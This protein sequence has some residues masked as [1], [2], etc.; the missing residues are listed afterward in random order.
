[1]PTAW[2]CLH[3]PS[4]PKF[5]RRHQRQLHA[6]E[7]DSWVNV[8]L[9]AP[10]SLKRATRQRK[11]HRRLR[12]G[13]LRRGR[14][15]DSAVV[16]GR[17][18]WCAVCCL[19]ANLLVGLQATFPPSRQPL[20]LTLGHERPH[21]RRSARNTNVEQASC[22]RSATV[23][24][25]LCRR[26]S[27][28]TCRVS[29]T[30]R[31]LHAWHLAQ[32]RYAIVTVGLRHQPSPSLYIITSSQQLATKDAGTHEH[33][34][35]VVFSRSRVPFSAPPVWCPQR[36]QYKLGCAGGGTATAAHGDEHQ[37]RPL[38]RGAMHCESRGKTDFGVSPS[39][40]ATNRTLCWTRPK[41]KTR[42]ERKATLAG[43]L[44]R[45]P[46][47]IFN[48]ANETRN[49]RRWRAIAETWSSNRTGKGS[50]TQ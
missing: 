40:T 34:R 45:V 18:P 21:L 30:T 36:P 31:S 29:S 1:M 42:A 48:G 17:A 10:A 3:R 26:L 23:T 35:R 44:P 8:S 4:I 7:V 5:A 38:V 19:M 27:T 15:G 2:S 16:R 47:K 50:R 9:P 20:V 37:L 43:M 12:R 46:S 13:T 32:P 33:P 39:R 49:L 24:N 6:E 11:H 22:K 28:P 14:Q 25:G 41:G